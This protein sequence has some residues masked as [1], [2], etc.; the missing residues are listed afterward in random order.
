MVNPENEVLQMILKMVLLS[1]SFPQ[2]HINKLS[3]LSS[4]NHMNNSEKEVD[5]VDAA[6]SDLEITLEGGKTSNILVWRHSHIFT[7]V[8]GN[9]FC[10]WITCVLGFKLIMWIYFP[11]Y[12]SL[13]LCLVLSFVSLLYSEKSVSPVKPERNPTSSRLCTLAGGRE[14]TINLTGRATF[15]IFF[16]SSAPERFDTW[17]NPTKGVC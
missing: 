15:G 17:T 7:F 16:M 10:L 6:L 3:I 9:G 2:Y 11:N 5:E 4:D 8:T 1:L 12:R 14:M 13:A